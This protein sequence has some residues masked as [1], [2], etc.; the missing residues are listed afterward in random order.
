MSVT[1][2]S[3]IRSAARQILSSEY[4]SIWD[5]SAI[6]NNRAR[7][8]PAMFSNKAVNLQYT[9]ESMFKQV[10]SRELDITENGIYAAKDKLRTAGFNSPDDL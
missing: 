9:T 4:T 10:N 8:A 7:P 5:T 1:D 6:L 3:T 2:Q